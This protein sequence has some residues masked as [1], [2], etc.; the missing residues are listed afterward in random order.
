MRAPPS[1]R[2]HRF[3]ASSGL[4]GMGIGLALVG[5]L[6]LGPGVSSADPP[7]I[8][9]D[10]VFIAA[11]AAVANGQVEKSPMLGFSI[12]KTPFEQLPPEGAVLV[13][14]DLGLGK[15]LRDGEVIYSLRPVFQTATGEISSETFGRLPAGMRPTRS[16]H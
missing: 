8:E 15:D 3:A 5:I 2:W 6:V 9:P 13:G 11:R 4:R 16:K 12:M 14:F 1:S 10:S 7:G